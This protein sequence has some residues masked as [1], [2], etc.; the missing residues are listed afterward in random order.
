MG[1]PDEQLTRERERER[2][3]YWPTAA[4]EMWLDPVSGFGS[5][6]TKPTH[7]HRLSVVTIS[8]RVHTLRNSSHVQL[9]HQLTL[10]QMC[11][12][13]FD[14]CIVQ[15]R[16]HHKYSLRGSPC[17]SSHARAVGALGHSLLWIYAAATLWA[18]TSA[19]VVCVCVYMILWAAPLLFPW[20]NHI[21]NILTVQSRVISN[22]LTF[23]KC[24]RKASVGKDILYI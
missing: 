23:P 12:W 6:L 24:R 17:D 18:Q 19:L 8:L 2:D 16:A 11:D 14:L 9:S 15:I 20:E 3:N 10:D 7:T 5:S 1:L 13:G 4:C 21:K 22:W